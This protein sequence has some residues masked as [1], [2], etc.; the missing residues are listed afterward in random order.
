MA[1]GLNKVLLIGHKSEK[2]PE[3]SYIPSELQ[4]ANSILATNESYKGDDGNLVENWNGIISPS[5]EN[6]LKYV[7]TH[8]LKGK[9]YPG[10]QDSDR[11]LCEKTARRIIFTKIVISDM[12]MFDLKSSSGET[13]LDIKHW[14]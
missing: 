8:L 11:Y 9:V 5:G 6:L 12:V 3:L 10:R 7:S 1:K 13:E 2:D 14:Q 4:S